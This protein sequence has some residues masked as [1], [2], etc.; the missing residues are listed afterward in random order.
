MACFVMLESDLDNDLALMI[1]F[2]A[3]E[4]RV[5]IFAFFDANGVLI[6]I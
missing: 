2:S 5:C 4:V 6:W 3:M 1:I